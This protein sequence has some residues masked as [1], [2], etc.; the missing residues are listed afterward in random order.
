M[1]EEEGWIVWVWETRLMEKAFPIQSLASSYLSKPCSTLEW[2]IFFH[3]LGKC[4]NLAVLCYSCLEREKFFLLLFKKSCSSNA[5]I[6]MQQNLVSWSAFIP[7][8]KF[9]YFEEILD[10]F[11]PG[12]KC[13]PLAWMDR[14]FGTLARNLLLPDGPHGHG[15][16]L[17]N[18][19][20]EGKKDKESPSPIT[21]V[22]FHSV[23]GLPC[24]SLV[25]SAC[26][27]RGS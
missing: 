10:N 7:I 26:R 19:V 12:R 18:D 2:E 25:R 5:L 1:E 3:S 24:G 11:F 23:P 9:L 22:V 27:V 8:V 13:G 20:H 4:G 15:A 6:G 14:P 16:L 17:A 21:R